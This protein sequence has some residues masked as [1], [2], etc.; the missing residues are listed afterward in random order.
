MFVS[1]QPPLKWSPHV[2]FHFCSF[3]VFLFIFQISSAVGFYMEGFYFFLVILILDV[4]LWIYVS[5]SLYAK[6]FTLQTYLFW[7]IS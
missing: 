3:I 4:F 6:K 1:F 5:I 2:R 7:K